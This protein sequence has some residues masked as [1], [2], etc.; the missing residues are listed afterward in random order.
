MLPFSA[1]YYVSDCSWQKC[2]VWGSNSRPSDYETD[3]LPTALTRQTFW[4]EASFRQTQIHFYR[5]WLIEF[6]KGMMDRFLAWKVGLCLLCHSMHY[7]DWLDVLLWG[8]VTSFDPL[9]RQ[10]QMI[11]ISQN[12]PLWGSNS[13]PSDYETDALPTALRR[14]TIHSKDTFEAFDKAQS[15]K[16]FK[17]YF[18]I[19]S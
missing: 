14:Q 2:P 8:L 6:L 9:L 4:M 17:I 15:S 19:I 3:A 12:C 5:L 18:L 16:H 1:N 11:Q 13:R 10:L 7:L